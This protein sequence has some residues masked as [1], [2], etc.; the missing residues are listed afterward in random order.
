MQEVKQHT[1]RLY[2]VLS[3]R[4][5]VAAPV[6]LMVEYIELVICNLEAS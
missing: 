1:L 4:A 3:G 5:S 2:Q 6:E